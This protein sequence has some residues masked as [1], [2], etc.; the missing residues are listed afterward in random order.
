[1]WEAWLICPWV[2]E[3]LLL[4][5]RGMDRFLEQWEMNARDLHQRTIL[6]ATPRGRERWHAMWPLTQG[7]TAPATAEALERDPH[8]IS[9]WA[10]PS[11]TA[12]SCA[13]TLPARNGTS[14]ERNRQ[15]AELAA[16]ARGNLK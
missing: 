7:W 1:M 15:L 16:A 4:G 10:R 12:A 9:Q 13:G 11:R 6:A 2:R 8:T 3:G 14:P 5:V